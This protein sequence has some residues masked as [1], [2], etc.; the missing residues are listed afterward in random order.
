MALIS[1]A[2]IAAFANLIPQETF[3]SY[4]FVLS[5][6]SIVALCALPGMF[7]SLIRASAQGNAGAF[8]YAARHQ[9]KWALAG[10]AALL[11]ISAWYALH[12]NITLSG[13]FLIAGLFFPFRYTFPVFETYWNGT[14]RFD[15]ENVLKIISATGT[16]LITIATL[17]LTNNLIIIFLTFFASYAVLDGILF[18][19]TK[20]KITSDVTPE[21]IQE[22]ISYGVHLTFMKSIGIIASNIDKVIVWKFLGPI[23]VAIYSF[24]QIPIQRIFSMIPITVLAF[25]KF[26]ESGVIQH[27]KAIFFRTLGLLPITVSIAITLSMISPLLYDL[28]FPNYLDSVAYFQTLTILVA[29]FPLLLFETALEAERQQKALYIIRTTTPIIKTV[30]F[31]VLVFIYGLAGMI[32]SIILA[33]LYKYVLAFYFFIKMRPN[34]NA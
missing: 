16:S 33:E 6:T 32:A 17:F 2:T 4:Q 13:S 24:A 34:T 25:P 14:K 9:M 15:I 18:F 1:L 19:Y 20:N 8:K 12:S 29:I 21:A 30:L 3:G 7:M 28:L 11:L 10:S 22:T 27:K 31:I 26:S 23:E 5:I